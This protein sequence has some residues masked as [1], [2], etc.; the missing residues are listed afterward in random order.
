MLL[1]A[2]RSTVDPVDVPLWEPGQVADR[3]IIAPFPFPVTKSRDEL[4]R[5]R[6]AAANREPPVYR[7]LPEAR[8]SALARL[9][10]LSR[11]VAREASAPFS[12]TTRQVIGD[13]RARAEVF[14]TAARLVGDIMSRRIVSGSPGGGTPFVVVSSEG[15]ERVLPPDSL[16]A[17]DRALAVLSAEA[18][19]RYPTNEEM[20]RAVFEIASGFVAPTVV[21]DPVTTELRRARAMEQVPAII[22]TMLAGEVIVEAHYRVTEADVAELRSLREAYAARASA[23]GVRGRVAPLVGH[24][25]WTLFFLVILAASLRCLSPGVLRSA[26]DA[27]LVAVLLGLLAFFGFAVH[28]WLHVPPSAVPLASVAIL[29]TVFFDAKVGFG[30]T[31][32]GLLLASSQVRFDL[33]GLVGPL[34]GALVAVFWIRRLRRR[35]DFLLAALWMSLA[36]AGAGVSLGL[37]FDSSRTVLVRTVVMSAANAVVSLVIVVAVFPLLEWLFH[38]TTDLRLLELLDMNHILLRQLALEAPGTYHHSMVVGNLA[39]AACDAIGGN[40]LL[41]RVGSYYHDIGKLTKPQYFSENQL[42]GEN[43]HDRLTPKMSALVIASHVKEGLRLAAKEGLPQPIRD[44]IAEHHGTSQISFFY[45]KMKEQHPDARIDPEDFSYAGPKPRSRETAV[46]MLADAAESATRAL[47]EP[48]PARIRQVVQ[49]VIGERLTSGQLDES[50]LT[51]RDLE[52]IREVF[53]PI[54]VGVHHHRVRYP[55]EEPSHAP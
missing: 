54:L 28:T 25:L 47:E 4:E 52:R 42:P 51:F 38:R 45:R 29:A 41:A 7:V 36:A 14:D 24:V 32:T 30:V 37:V 9:A 31:M 5:E 55:Q 20:A 15:T 13:P 40:G 39:E 12:E 23:A 26:N 33:G 17:M 27:T 49:R 16:L 53:I 19:S 6:Q 35:T 43:P 44:F 2:L 48:T 34:S 11:D 3:T 46:V 8:P 10:T 22:G 1:I 21:M 18:R 50:N